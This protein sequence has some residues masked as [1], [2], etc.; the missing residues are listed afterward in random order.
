MGISTRKKMEKRLPARVL[1]QSLSPWMMMVCILTMEEVSR[2]GQQS[3]QACEMQVEGRQ[4][5]GRKE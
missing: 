5:H 4:T 1:I 2:K 3:V